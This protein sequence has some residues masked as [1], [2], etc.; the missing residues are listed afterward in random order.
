MVKRNL[1][2]PLFLVLI[3]TFLLAGCD[4]HKGHKPVETVAPQG[5]P[6]AGNAPN[7]TTVSKIVS[8]RCASCHNSGPLNWT[9]Q[10]IFTAI[11][12]TGRLKNA[13]ASGYMPKKPSPEST[14]ITDAERRAIIEWADSVSASPAIAMNVSA[15]KSPFALNDKNLAFVNRCITCHGQFGTSAAEDFPNLAGHGHDYY[16]ARFAQFLDPK[17]EGLMPMQLKS[18]LAEFGATVTVDEKGVQYSE[19]AKALLEFAATYFNSFQPN[20]KAAELAALREKFSA[21]QKTQYEKA[22]AQFKSTCVACHLGADLKPMLANA[23]MVLNQK[24][25]YI[26]KRFEEFKS[27]KGGVMMPAI[28]S[29][30]SQEDLDGLRLYLSTT[31]W[32]EVQNK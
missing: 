25:N 27:G 1:V 26:K 3:G 30:L 20:P 5:A 29:G 16:F 9:D 6:T 7:Y 14:L 13:I 18:I 19:E 8:A 21:E 10:T 15:E 12:K 22:A 2:N 31:H 17:A 4:G 28:V 32:S 11:A 23:P 24:S